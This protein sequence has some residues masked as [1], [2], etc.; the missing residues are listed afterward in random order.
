MYPGLLLVLLA[1]AAGPR[2][3]A[4][5]P[6]GPAPDLLRLNRDIK[7]DSKPLVIAAD[8]IF[9]WVDGTQRVI[10]MRGRVLAQQS[11]VHARFQQG[12]AWIDLARWKSGILHVSLY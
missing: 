2:A 5:P 7:G 9:T 4:Q 1:G 10:V 6:P 8:E 3:T 11:V 12:V